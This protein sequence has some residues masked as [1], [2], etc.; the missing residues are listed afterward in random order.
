[1]QQQHIT[2][3]DQ[4][5]LMLDHQDLHQGDVHFTPAGSAVQAQQAA[6]RI[7]KLLPPQ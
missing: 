7:L 4:H 2:I 6:Q 1:M 5:A 3:D